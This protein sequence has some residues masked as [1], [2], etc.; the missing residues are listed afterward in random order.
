MDHYTAIISVMIV[1]FFEVV[2][3]C[4]LYGKDTESRFHLSSN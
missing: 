3:V 4:W 1:A 2:A